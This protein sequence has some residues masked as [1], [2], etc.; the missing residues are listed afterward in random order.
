MVTN[1]IEK[2]EPHALTGK[3]DAGVD[4]KCR[5][6]VPPDIRSA[7]LDE[8]I[9]YLLY[10][11]KGFRNRS[12]PTTLIYPEC[13]LDTDI[14]KYAKRDFLDSERLT[15]FRQFDFRELDGTRLRLQEPF[16]IRAFG[17][18]YRLESGK[19]IHIVGNYNHM[20]VTPSEEWIKRVQGTRT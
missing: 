14:E 8:Q 3:F 6:P 20:I 2:T 5:F 11:P 13:F 7:T 19:Q 17:P 1:L 10:M 4:H 15:F 18:N 12:V 9:Y 16:L